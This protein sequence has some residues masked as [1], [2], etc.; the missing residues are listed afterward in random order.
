VD[1]KSIEDGSSN[2]ILLAEKAVAVQNYTAP[3][4]PYPYWEIY[5]YYTGADWPVMRIFGALRPDAPIKNPEIRVMSDSDARTFNYEHGFGSA[6]PGVLCSVWGDGA[7]KAIS[8]SADLWV[9]DQLG[10]RSDQ[11]TV[12]A[13]DL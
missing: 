11:S 10:K 3:N 12:S 4:S 5:G 9:L 6:H 1:F 13:N 8:T 2:T 7:T